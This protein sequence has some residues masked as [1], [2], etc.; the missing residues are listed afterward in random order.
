MKESMIFLFLIVISFN[1]FSQYENDL[2]DIV[3]G[4]ELHED[5]NSSLEKII[6]SDDSGFYALKK[7]KGD[8]F[9]EHFDRELTRIKSVEINLKKFGSKRR[10][11]DIILFADKLCLLSSEIRVSKMT[12]KFYLQTVNNLSLL[13]NDDEFMVADFPLKGYYEKREEL[14]NL[15]ISENQ[16]KLLV[17]YDTPHDKFGKEKFGF[18]V[19]NENLVEIRNDFMELPVKENLFEMERFKV[20][21]DGNVFLLGKAYKDKRRD[22]RHG[23]PNFKFKLYV[24]YNHGKERAEKE[25]SLPDKF[26][27]DIQMALLPEGNL[28]VAGF[29]S[30][31]GTSSILGSFYIKIDKNTYETIAT[32][33]EELGIDL[34]T[35][36]MKEREEKKTKKDADKGINVELFAYDIREFIITNDGGFIL[37][38]E[39]FYEE[40]KT[41]DGKYSDAT[42]IHY[43]YNDILALKMNIDGNVVWREKIGKRQETVN[44]NGYYSSFTYT[45]K[46]NNIYY[47]FNDNPKNIEYNGSGKIYNFKKNPDALTVVVKLSPEGGQV[48]KTLFASGQK[49]ILI[50]PSNSFVEHEGELIIFGKRRKNQQFA[51]LIVNED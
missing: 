2:I 5:K 34:I 31:E 3:W 9:L 6:G 23:N 8:Y 1:T 49:D 41:I 22:V 28:V 46:N 15:V 36:N 25:I 50:S 43:Y 12:K 40:D 27:T 16:S 24:F 4:A 13:P 18:I 45:I 17:Y 11:E 42:K 21:N 38:G 47:I 14:F 30:E 35:E 7:Y 26:I 32:K 33:T 10:F 39:Q 51:R 37:M 48:R 20:D 29:Y 44:D 19:L